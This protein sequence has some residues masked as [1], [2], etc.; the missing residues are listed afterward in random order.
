MATIGDARQFRGG[1]HLAAYLGLVPK[2]HLGGEKTVLRRISKR[3]N[4]YLRKLLI[5]GAKSLCQKRNLES[6]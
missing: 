5:H 6:G 2:Q 1:W 3:G 4:K